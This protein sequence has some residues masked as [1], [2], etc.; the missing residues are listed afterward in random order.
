MSLWSPCPMSFST[1]PARRRK[2]E[3][4]R[5]A[6]ASFDH[7]I[8]QMMIHGDRDRCDRATSAAVMVLCWNEDLRPRQ[9][10]LTTDDIEP[11]IRVFNDWRYDNNWGDPYHHYVAFPWEVPMWRSRYIPGVSPGMRPEAFSKS[12]IQRMKWIR[13]QRELVEEALRTAGTKDARINRIVGLM[14]LMEAIHGAFEPD[15]FG[16]DEE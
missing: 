11:L 2:L 13:E 3:L 10:A 14:L 6:K 15:L 12:I 5:H 16:Y 9:D 7:R 8:V 4:P 1:R